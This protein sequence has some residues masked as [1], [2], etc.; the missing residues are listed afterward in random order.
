M[1][2]M[3]NKSE[4]LVIPAIILSL[5]LIISS[6]IGVYTFYKI[7]ALDN[8]LSVTGSAKTNVTSDSVKWSSSIS[9][10]V[11]QGNI[12][13]GYRG[14]ASDIEIVKKFLITKGVKDSE[15]TI[16]PIFTNEIYKYNPSGDTGPREYNLV[17][18]IT[19]NSS[20]VPKITAVA[21]DTQDIINK[22][23]FFS[24]QSPEYYYSKLADLRVSLLG[25][26]IKDAKLRAEMLAQSSDRSV[27]SL[28]SAA[29]GVVQV[30][31]PNSI[32]V[33]DYGQY[34][35]SSIEKDVMITVRASFSV[36]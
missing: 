2:K 18:N 25:D 35:T 32:E 33:S 16:S 34:D 4:F 1:E 28:K 8:T 14:L 23:V 7:R 17:Q 10:N 19:I 13:E 5:G 6:T 15:I 26:A 3:E 9:R 24:N 36:N 11:T 30:L 29:S 20:D 12:K 31:A 27:G 21:K 22:G